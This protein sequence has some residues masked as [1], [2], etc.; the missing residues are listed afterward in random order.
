MWY[1]GD[2]YDYSYEQLCTVYGE[3]VD[4]SYTIFVKKG[5]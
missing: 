2:K 1:A 5:E 3:C 4:V